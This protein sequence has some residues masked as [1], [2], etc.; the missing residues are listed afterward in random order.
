MGSWPAWCGYSQSQGAGVLIS[1]SAPVSSTGTGFGPLSS[2]ERVLVGV[3]LLTRVALPCG[4]CPEASMTGGELTWIGMDEYG[5]ALMGGW[6]G[7]C[8][9][10]Q[11]HGRP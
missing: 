2:R 6:T 10:S 1:S 5:Y 8:G 4:Y 9:Y 3:V 7:C 11:S